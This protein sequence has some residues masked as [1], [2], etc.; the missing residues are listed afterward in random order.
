MDY[1]RVLTIQDISC[2]GQ[3][4]LTVALPVLSACGHETAVLPSAVL[5]T[6]TSGFQ[7]FTFRNLSD[8]MPAIEKHWVQSGI[9]FDAVYTGYLGS[10]EHVAHVLSITRRCM[11][12]GGIVFIDPAMADHGQLYAGFDESYV[13][14][15]KGLCKH[16]HY[17]LPNIT[18]AC[19][20]T[21]IPYQESYEKAYIDLLLEGLTKLCPNVILTGVS[22]AP[23]R[24]G[25]E[26]AEN[27]NRHYYQHIRLPK[28]CH[29]TGDI[30][31]STFVGAK[32][33]GKTAWEAAKIAADY[34]VSC[35]EATVGSPEHWYGVKFEPVLGKLINM[36]NK[37]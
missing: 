7:D 20:L 10:A 36:L 24:T 17:I 6:H 27:G 37:N 35:I 18:E 4:S 31:S 13:E 3:C 9:T 30:F 19:L 16:A 2:L 29:G 28:V 23:D 21:G 8:D 33:K 26:V 11:K 12:K 1:K 15:M 5:S 14:A 32:L 22:Y 25:I 34:T